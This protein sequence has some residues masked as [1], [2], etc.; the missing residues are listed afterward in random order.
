MKKGMLDGFVAHDSIHD[1]A[2]DVLMLKTAQ[3]YAFGLEDFPAESDI[4]ETTMK[5][6]KATT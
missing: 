1:C 3:R 5:K 2:K 4:D 6:K